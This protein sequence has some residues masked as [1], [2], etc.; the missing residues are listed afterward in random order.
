MH[1]GI[2][3]IIVNELTSKGLDPSYV[4]KFTLEITEEGCYHL[5][6]KNPDVVDIPIEVFEIVDKIIDTD[7]MEMVA[8]GLITIE[9]TKERRRSMATERPETLYPEETI[10][11][12]KRL[13]LWRQ[14]VNWVKRIFKL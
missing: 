3:N 13:S 9:E 7:E 11:Q 4:S 6:L 10:S 2:R 5:G 1:E 12:P 8:R 14:F